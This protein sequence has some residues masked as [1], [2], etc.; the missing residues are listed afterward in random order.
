MEENHQIHEPVASEPSKDPS[1]SVQP[2]KP[3]ESYGE[4]NTPSSFGN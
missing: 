4:E 3:A 1:K 2:H